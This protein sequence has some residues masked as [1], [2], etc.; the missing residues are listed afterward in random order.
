[1]WKPFVLNN[2]LSIKNGKGITAEEIEENPGNLCA[3]QSGEE[4]NGVL[5]KISLNYCKLKRYTVS[6][7]PCL[8]VART[9][10][11]GFVSFQAE[12]CV[13]G[14][15]AKLLLLKDDDVASI[16]IYMFLQTILLANRFK[17]SYGRKVTE[18]KY[19]Y[20]I[21]DLPIKYISKNVPFIDKTFKYSEKGYVPDWNFMEKYIKSLHCKPLTTKNKHAQIIDLNTDKWKDFTLNRIFT[22]RGGFFNKK[23]EHSKKGLFPFL[24]ATEINNGIT[25]YYTLEDIQQYNKTGGEDFVLEQKIYNGNCVVIVVD[26]SVGNAFY[27]ADKFTCSHSITACYLDGYTMNSSIGIFLCTVI[28]QDK[29][30]WSYGR[31]PH[32]IKKLG[33]TIIKLPVKYNSDGSLIVDK[34]YQYSDKGYIPDWQFMER[35]IKSLPYG[36]RI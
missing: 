27:Q 13:V 28:M 9:G 2:I 30:R 36:D 4:N 29:Y 33:E 31:K 20:E 3:V 35:Y 21:I 12:G 5:G 19:M 32:D 14:D 7:K 25:E 10:S 6:E 17:Y 23:P 24:G 26:G 15:S 18:E 1:M 34:T 8:T 22:L 16:E 11:A